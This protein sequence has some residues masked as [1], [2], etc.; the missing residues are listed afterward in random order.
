VG[1][2]KS[3]KWR[4][5]KVA[6]LAGKFLL[7]NVE[8]QSQCL[9]SGRDQVVYSLRPHASYRSEQMVASNVVHHARHTETHIVL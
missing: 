9:R 7:G 8:I 4:Y 6:C 2:H 5:I 3:Y 1:G